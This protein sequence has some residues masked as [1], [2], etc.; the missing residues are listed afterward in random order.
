[1]KRLIFIIVFVLITMVLFAQ[2]RIEI[3]EVD[4]AVRGVWHAQLISYDGG[5]STKNGEGIAI[6][7]VFGTY[8]ISLDGK[9]LN[10]D[11][12]YY[13]ETSDKSPCN[14]V[15]LE[16]GTTV[17]FITKQMPPYI[18]VQVWDIASN[19]ETMRVFVTQQ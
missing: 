11:H 12:I 15:F 10:F 18:L 13:T 16:G 9:R 6:F 19:R 14:V 2:Q 8:A 7:R 17:W 1:M 4:P 3:M 5:S